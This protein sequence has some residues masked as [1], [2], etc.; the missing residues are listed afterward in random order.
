MKNASAASIAASSSADARAW[1]FSDDLDLSVT[2]SNPLPAL[3]LAVGHIHQFTVR[4]S[5]STEPDAD[6]IRVPGSYH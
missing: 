6:K 2:V 4:I 5:G 3:D 1:L